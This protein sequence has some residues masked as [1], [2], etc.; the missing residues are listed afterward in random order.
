ME[1]DLVRRF[2]LGVCLWVG[3]CS[4]SRLTPQGAAI[5]SYLSCV[6]LPSVVEDHY[7]RDSKMGNDVFLNELADLDRSD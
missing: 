7:M 1:D 6:K 2:S 5:V 4:E 3:R